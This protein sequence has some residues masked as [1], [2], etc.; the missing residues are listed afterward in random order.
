MYVVRDGIIGLVVFE[1]RGKGNGVFLADM[2]DNGDERIVRQFAR[3][4]KLFALVVILG[5]G[6]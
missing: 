2:A 4:V 1:L 3:Q 6:R 5:E